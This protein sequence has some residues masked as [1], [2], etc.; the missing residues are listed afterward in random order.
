MNLETNFFDID[1]TEEEVLQE[2]KNINFYDIKAYL[3]QQMV[4]REE[5]QPLL[6]KRV[7]IMK[8]HEFSS[9]SLSQRY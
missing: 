8:N 7:I 4:L 1:K 2:V 6:K 9:R 5:K 3:K